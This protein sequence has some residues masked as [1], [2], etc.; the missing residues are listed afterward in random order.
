MDALRGD[1]AQWWQDRWWLATHYA[2]TWERRTF[3]KM[4][5]RSTAPFLSTSKVSRSGLAARSKDRA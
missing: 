3:R 1:L 2:A 5:W 4:D